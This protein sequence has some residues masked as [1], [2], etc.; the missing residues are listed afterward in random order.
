LL[1]TTGTSGSDSSCI[2][3]G[4]DTGYWPMAA[5]IEILAWKQWWRCFGP[6][7]PYGNLAVVMEVF[8]DNGLRWR[9]IGKN[10]ITLNNY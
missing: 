5:V 1:L 7:V 8:P 10:T 6:A 2:G 3:S 4:G 9:V